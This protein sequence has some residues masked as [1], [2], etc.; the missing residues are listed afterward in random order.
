[1]IAQALAGFF[2]S[3]VFFLKRLIFSPRS[4]LPSSWLRRGFS[5]RDFHEIVYEHLHD[6]VQKS[7][8][9]GAHHFLAHGKKEGRNYNQTPAN[10]N[11]L[12]SPRPGFHM[13]SFIFEKRL[14]SDVSPLS[15]FLT[16]G[17][18]S[19][20]WTL[21]QVGKYLPRGVEL[22]PK[23]ALHFHCHYP[24]LLGEFIE[25]AAPALTQ[26][27]TQL[28]VTCS[29]QATLEALTRH[30]RLRDY[31]ARIVL[32]PNIGRNIGALDFVLHSREFFEFDI[33]G[34]FHSK[35]SEHLNP[36]ATSSWRTFIYTSLLS[37]GPNGVGYHDIIVALQRN[38]DL[39]IVFPDDPHEFGWGLN[40]EI[41][42]V[43][44]DELG[45]QL[46][47]SPPKFP[48]GAMFVARR[49]FLEHLFAPLNE[50]SLQHSEPLGLDG[51]L[52][53]AFERLLGVLPAHLSMTIALNRG[54]PEGYAWHREL[55]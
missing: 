3:T 13:N 41:A 51:T 7:P 5:P 34:H 37:G 15:E 38:P 17:S 28:V 47:P 48:V 2:R 42:S 35:T 12:I 46:D 21:P 31:R 29:Q 54:D 1:M 49:S 20:R 50:H 30:P 44:M 14:A 8:M 32:V 36:V 40:Y 22:L 52:W 25:F 18:P 43:I 11:I 45:L 9:S 16:Q 33:W 23:S 55:A 4:P 26:P 24:E 39:A 10:S 19:G 27:Y 53:H 6:D